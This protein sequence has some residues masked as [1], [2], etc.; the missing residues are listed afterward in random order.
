MGFVG[1][2]KEEV[3]EGETVGP[4]GVCARST[5]VR[6]WQEWW[7]GGDARVSASAREENDVLGFFNQEVMG[8]V[9]VDVEGEVG[10][11]EAEVDDESELEELRLLLLVLLK[12]N[13]ELAR[14]IFEIPLPLGDAEVVAAWAQAAQYP[15]LELPLLSSTR[16][17]VFELFPLPFVCLLSSASHSTTF[18]R[19]SRSWFCLLLLRP[20]GVDV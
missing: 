19:P 17:L 5:G 16:S 1:D 12:D 14:E 3:E 6:R 20:W 7:D 10:A 4:S 18:S 8:D 9:E 2:D 13:H 11:V 15:V